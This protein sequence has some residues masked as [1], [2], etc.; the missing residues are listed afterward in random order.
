MRERGIA[1]HIKDSGK[2]KLKRAVRM[3]SS[4]T[5]KQKITAGVLYNEHI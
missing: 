3:F 4:E 2:K 5:H 1:D